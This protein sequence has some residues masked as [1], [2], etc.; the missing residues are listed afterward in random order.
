MRNEKWRMQIECGVHFHF[1]FSISHFSF[2][3]PRRP[4]LKHQFH[5]LA[6]RHPDPNAE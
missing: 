1:A 6:A 4:R 3:I 5:R 2:S